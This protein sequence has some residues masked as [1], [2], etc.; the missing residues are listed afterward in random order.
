MTNETAAIPSTD[1]GA[2]AYL[3]MIRGERVFLRPAEKSDVQT[4]VPIFWEGELIA[5][6]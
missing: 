3:P 5:W 6:A 2:P 1:G 4:F